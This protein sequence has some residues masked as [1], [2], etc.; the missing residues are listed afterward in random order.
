MGGTPFPPELGSIVGLEVKIGLLGDVVKALS[1][2]ETLR[3]TITSPDGQTIA[4]LVLR[5]VRVFEYPEDPA[6][7]QAEME[8]VDVVWE[9]KVQ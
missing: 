6:H 9:E 3:Q 5:P 4:K 7:F 1:G 8:V 2:E